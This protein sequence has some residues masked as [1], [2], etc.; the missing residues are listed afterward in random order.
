M[1]VEVVIVGAGLAGLCCA[2]HLTK[3]GISVLLLEASDAVGGRLRTDIVEGFQLDRGFQV[4]LTS[5]PE[6]KRVL[7]LSSLQLRKFRPG[8]MVRF[9]GRFLPVYRSMA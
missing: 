4:F 5:Y 3:L 6:A 9:Q 1:K 2:R 7:D 8:A